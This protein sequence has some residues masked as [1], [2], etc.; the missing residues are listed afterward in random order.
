MAAGK[1][2]VTL[3][4]SMPE[5]KNKCCQQPPT[6]VLTAG[7]SARLMELLEP[8]IAEQ[9]EHVQAARKNVFQLGDPGHRFDMH[10]MG[11]QTRSH[12]TMPSQENIPSRTKTSHKRIAQPA[13]SKTLTIL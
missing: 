4:L 5:R 7:G 12:S 2:A 10:G 3:L 9:R 6:K 13:C 8:E 1:E 11:R